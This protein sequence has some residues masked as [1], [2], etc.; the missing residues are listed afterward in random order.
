MVNYIL[1]LDNY[2]I[3]LKW[4]WQIGRKLTAP[5]FSNT[6]ENISILKNTRDSEQKVQSP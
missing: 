2:V 1:V 5:F 6:K 4:N 3:L